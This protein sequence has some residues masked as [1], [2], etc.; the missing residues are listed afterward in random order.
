MKKVELRPLKSGVQRIIKSFCIFPRYVGS[1]VS[2]QKVW[3]QKV[4]IL[5][6][7]RRTYFPEDYYTESW[8]D[9][10]FVSKKE[11]LEWKSKNVRYILGYYK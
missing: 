5:Q 11:Y 6:E 1:G 4:Y 3:M 9:I 7:Y 8:R 2:K 10:Q